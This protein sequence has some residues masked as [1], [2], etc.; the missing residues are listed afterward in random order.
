MCLHIK[1]KYIISCSQLLYKL[2]TVACVLCH[3]PATESCLFALS[4]IWS[5]FFMSF[6]LAFCKPSLEVCVCRCNEIPQMLAEVKK[7]RCEYSK[8]DENTVTSVLLQLLYIIK[9]IHI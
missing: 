6:H 7:K 2:C 3:S 9:D 1:T 5:F 4:L 8:T